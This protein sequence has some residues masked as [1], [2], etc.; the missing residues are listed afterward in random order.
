MSGGKSDYLELKLLDHVLG[1]AD[2]TRP[3]TVYVAVYTTKPSDAGGGTEVTGGAYARVTFT[4]NGTN[5]PAASAGQKSNGVAITFATATAPWGK[6]VAF[7][8]FDAASSGNLLYW[9][10]LLGTQQVF[11][12]DSST[13]FITCTAHGYSDGQ[14]VEVES[15][16]GTVPGGLA[17]DT[18]YYVRDSTANT[19]KLTATPGGSAI[20]LTTNGTGK[21]LVALSY[22]KT[23]SQGDTLSFAIGQLKINED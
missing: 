23:V 22:K 9:G 13:D 8:I 11:T 19:F 1:G 3:A 16:G 18:E 20:D 12:A 4:N 14:L 17:D 6:C 15:D 10:E 2:Y 7:G 21:L 5:W